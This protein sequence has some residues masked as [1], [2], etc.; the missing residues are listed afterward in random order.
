MIIAYVSSVIIILSSYPVIFKGI[1]FTFHHN[2]F[3][4][5]FKGKVVKP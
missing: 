3:T 1:I 2:N 4:I 5:G